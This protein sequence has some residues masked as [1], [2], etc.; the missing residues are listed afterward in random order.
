MCQKGINGEEAEVVNKRGKDGKRQNNITSKNVSR[1]MMV[2][3]LSSAPAC[4]T[5][6][7]IC[8]SKFKDFE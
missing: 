5:V 6:R 8:A 3:R 7:I 4:S 2:V 1:K